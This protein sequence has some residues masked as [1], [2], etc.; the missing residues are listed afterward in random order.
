MFKLIAPPYFE[1]S[2]WLGAASLVAL[3]VWAAVT[4]RRRHGGKAMQEDSLD[5]EWRSI[6]V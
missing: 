1:V 2:L 4:T 6:L 5:R 3:L